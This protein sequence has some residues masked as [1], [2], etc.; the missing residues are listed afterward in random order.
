MFLRRCSALVVC[1][2]LVFISFDVRAF[3]RC[4]SNACPRR[5][6]VLWP[7]RVQVLYFVGLDCPL[8]VHCVMHRV[9]HVPFFVYGISEFF[10]WTGVC[11]YLNAT[12]AICLQHAI[13][14][15]QRPDFPSE[16]FV[17]CSRWADAF[18]SDNFAAFF[19]S[20]HGVIYTIISFGDGLRMLSAPA[21]LCAPDTFCGWHVA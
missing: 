7:V 9:R 13:S 3:S 8:D 17:S 4:W 1:L 21:C 18:S 20:S 5:F 15:S 10:I 12:F 14:F 19:L 11:S 6:A 16:H 2:V